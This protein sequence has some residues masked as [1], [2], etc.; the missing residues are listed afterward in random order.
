MLANSIVALDDEIIA[1]NGVVVYSKEATFKAK[2]V[3]YN[4]KEKTLELF[5][6]VEMIVENKEYTKTD[7]LKVNLSKNI[8]NS[9]KFF[10]Y[11]EDSDIWLYSSNSK[12]NK[13]RYHLKN[14]VISS[15][16]RND[17]D[18]TI[19][20][21]DGLY[22]KKSEF[23]S[24]TNASLYAGNIPV[25]YLPWFGFSVNKK[26]KTGLLRPIIGFENSE[27]FFFV[28]PYYIAEKKNWDLEFDPQIRL[29][30]GV[31]MYATFRFSDTNSSHGSLRVG[32]FREKSSYRRENNLKNS[33]HKG[34]EFKY[35]NNALLTKSLIQGESFKEGL[36]IDATYLNDVDYLNLQ[37]SG[38]QTIDKLVT[39]RI[40]Y[41][42]SGDIDYFGIYAKYFI[43]TEKLSNDD[44]LQT[45]PSIQ[46]HRFDR[47]FLI[48]NLIYSLDYKYKRNKRKIGLGA[49]QHEFS[50]PLTFH[51]SLFDDLI[52]F[53]ASEHLYYSKIKYIDGNNTTDN[54]DYFSNY[55]TLSISS[56]LIKKYDDYIHNIQ[57]D[58]SLVIPSIEKK[59]GYF[60]DFIPFALEKE[61]LRLSVNEYF[62]KLDGTNY[63]THR[64]K[65]TI[66]YD[67]QL[68]KYA[69]LENQVIYK[70]YDFLSLNSNINYS[71]LYGKISKLQTSVHYLK[72]MYDFRV[73]HTYEYNRD[74]KDV[75]YLTSYL[76]AKIDN[77]YSAFGSFAYDIEDSFTK[78]WTFGWKM[79]KK[80]WDYMIRY[81]ESV[82]PAL[83]SAG[84]ESSIKR[85]IRLLLRLRPI[86]GITYEYNKEK[87]LNDQE[88]ELQEFL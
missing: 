26:R 42:I 17:P 16:N 68:Y 23:I 30:R 82:T 69:D 53:S 56:D 38:Y 63:L 74:K 1:D 48:D 87:S 11:N 27:N 37:H 80:C 70:P 78:E 60:A 71:H 19:R 83:T 64:L 59:D 43:D 86:G 3:I 49:S 2:K 58:A 35:E 88:S 9:K 20:F 47:D 76:E 21:T 7:Y 46:Y 79:K 54:A 77:R 39:S 41:F 51:L 29:D 12:S 10:L 24:L 75:N 45:L 36:L 6:D 40:N 14:S 22:N 57:L 84:A 32:Q 18:W 62:Y 52:N 5:D 66:Y 72:D 65:Q 34:L 13:N 31:G 25:F 8:H 28:Q 4:R 73:N 67:D 44:T 33:I 61:S 81:K 15:C 55:H 50:L 85:G